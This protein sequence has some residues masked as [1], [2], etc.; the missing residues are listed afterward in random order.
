MRVGND[1]HDNVND[2]RADLVISLRRLM[3]VV[4]RPL[5]VTTL[6]APCYPNLWVGN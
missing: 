5:K 1:L 6:V 4:L 3:A 2:H